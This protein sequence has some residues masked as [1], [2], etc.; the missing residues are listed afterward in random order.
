MRIT[1]DGAIRSDG[2]FTR[3][4]TLTGT[5]NGTDVI[6]S[7]GYG[8]PGAVSGTVEVFAAA[9]IIGGGNLSTRVLTFNFSGANNAG[10]GAHSSNVN[11]SV[12]GTQASADTVYTNITVVG[13]ATAFQPTYTLSVYDSVSVDESTEVSAGAL[14]ISV[15]DSLSVDDSPTAE[16]SES[17]PIDIP[18]IVDDVS[19]GEYAYLVTGDLNVTVSDHVAV[20]EYAKPEWIIATGY[21]R[22]ELILYTPDGDCILTCPTA[23]IE[24]IVPDVITEMTLISPNDEMVLLAPDMEVEVL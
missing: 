18:V 13:A 6:F 10:G 16:L 11:S 19:V 20:G 8:F 14:S 22:Q 4:K 24:L 5:A 9:G 3:S 23:D 15:E 1:A 21:L 17:G 12:L 7:V 2:V